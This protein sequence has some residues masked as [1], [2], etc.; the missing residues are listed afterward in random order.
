ALR[1]LGEPRQRCGEER[2]ADAFALCA[3]RDAEELDDA[4][5]VRA[6]EARDEGDAVPFG[7]HQDRLR[8]TR[9]GVLEPST[10]DLVAHGGGERRVVVVAAEREDLRELAEDGL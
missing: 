6:D 10:M 2:L 9:E 3:L 1:M 7:R 5:A 4:R 8:A